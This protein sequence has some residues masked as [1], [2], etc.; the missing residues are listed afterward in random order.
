MDTAKIA[1]GHLQTFPYC[2]KIG[3]S[4]NLRASVIVPLTFYR[5]GVGFTHRRIFGNLAL[6]KEKFSFY[7][8]LFI[9]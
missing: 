9:V 5:V 6:I 2:K 7:L 8:L 3:N 4:A 1:F